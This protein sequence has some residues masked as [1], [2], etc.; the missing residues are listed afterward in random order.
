MGERKMR[1]LV[2]AAR[3]P[4]DGDLGANS[5]NWGRARA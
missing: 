5:E 4:P 2:G 1:W 3:L